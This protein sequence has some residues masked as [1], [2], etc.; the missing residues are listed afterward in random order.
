MARLAYLQKVIGGLEKEQE[1]FGEGEIADAELQRKTMQAEKRI[2]ELQ[3][4]IAALNVEKEKRVAELEQQLALAQAELKKKRAETTAAVEQIT[5]DAE[6]VL[7]RQKCRSQRV[8][9]LLQPFT[10][11]SFWQPGRERPDETVTKGP[12]SLSRLRE[13]GALDNTSRGLTALLHIACRER[14]NDSRPKWSFGKNSGF[15]G[16]NDQDKETMVEA[17]GYL[18]ELGEALVAEG[19]LAP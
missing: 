8:R 4:Q 19:M 11:A 6:M 12:I 3:A 7:L 9:E 18:R 17:Q 5:S 1:S 16:L 2:G 13:E 10:A 14:P 15:D